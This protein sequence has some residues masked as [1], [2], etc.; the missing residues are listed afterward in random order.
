MNQSRPR[1]A[2]AAKLRAK[3]RPLASAPDFR[4]RVRA[5]S[6][7]DRGAGGDADRARLM[8]K[9]S[10]EGPDRHGPRQ[11]G[12][13]AWR[14]P[15]SARARSRP[16]RPPEGPSW[17]GRLASARAATDLEQAAARSSAWFGSHGD[18]HG[19]PVEV[20]GTC[21]SAVG[22]STCTSDLPPRRVNG[23]LPMAGTVTVAGDLAALMDGDPNLGEACAPA[24]RSRGHERGAGLDGRGVSSRA[25]G[26]QH[27]PCPIKSTGGRGHSAGQAAGSPREVPSRAPTDPDRFPASARR[28][29]SFRT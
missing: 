20:T 8:K 1:R 21:S 22:R 26:S 16:G 24:T 3:F 4:D 7:P 19:P 18:R 10:A 23:S 13:W 28:D 11:H 2:V 9:L 6:T 25:R 5:S 29:A 15:S 14:W 17:A 27:V 12:Q